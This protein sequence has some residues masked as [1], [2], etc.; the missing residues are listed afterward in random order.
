MKKKISGV[1]TGKR[2][3]LQAHFPW[4]ANWTPLPTL[5]CSGPSVP[6]PLLVTTMSLVDKGHGSTRVL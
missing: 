1:P 2:I 3:H 4:C 6:T 5:Q